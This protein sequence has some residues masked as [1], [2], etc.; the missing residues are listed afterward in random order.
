MRIITDYG[1]PALKI[2]YFGMSVKLSLALFLL[3]AALAPFLV[4]L[5]R[6]RS[7]GKPVA[8]KMRENVKE[9]DESEKSAQKRRF[10]LLSLLYWC[11]ASLRYI[12]DLMVGEELLGKLCSGLL[13]YELPVSATLV[14]LSGGVLLIRQNQD[15]YLRVLYN[16][17]EALA[18]LFLAATQYAQQIPIPKTISV[19]IG[20]WLILLLLW[21][22]LLWM[23]S[24]EFSP[25]KQELTEEERIF[26]PLDNPEEIFPRLRPSVA[27]L[28]SLI[29][30]APPEPY[31]ICVSGGWGSGKTSVVNAALAQLQ[32][33]AERPAAGG[34]HAAGAEDGSGR[35]E[36]VL[37][38]RYEVIRINALEL[39]E[40]R[41]LLDHAFSE[42]RRCLK[43]QGVYVGI[44]SEYRDFVSSAIAGMSNGPLA[45]LFTRFLIPDEGSYRE[46]RANL[47]S[48]LRE[49][50]GG[51]R[52]LIVVDDMERC[53]PEKTAQY[54]FF[55]KEIAAMSHCVAIFVTDFDFL[56]QPPTLDRELTVQER[57]TGENT[58]QNKSEAEKRRDQESRQQEKARYYEKFFNVRLD[59]PALSPKDNFRE[60]EKQ[61]RHQQLLSNAGRVLTDE[62][63]YPSEIIDT[64]EQD[65]LDLEGSLDKRFTEFL[66][67]P[68]T[69]K[70]FLF[71]RK[72]LYEKID[73]AFAEQEERAKRDG[74]PPISEEDILRRFENIRLDRILFLLAFMEACL[75]A[76][77]A[78]LQRNGSTYWDT[79]R[80]DGTFTTARKLIFALGQ[81]SLFR[82]NEVHPFRF[83]PDSGKLN[84]DPDY[85]QKQARQF[86]DFLFHSPS[87]LPTA[88]TG[89][90]S[91][92]QG[93]LDT[94]ERLHKEPLDSKKC[95][96]LE[97]NFN[98]KDVLRFVIRDIPPEFSGTENGQK[99]IYP[100]KQY[101]EALIQILNDT[102]GS[103]QAVKNLLWFF[104]THENKLSSEL[105][106]LNAMEVMWN[107]FQESGFSDVDIAYLQKFSEFSLHY[108]HKSLDVLRKILLNYEDNPHDSSDSPLT[109]A[110][111]TFFIRFSQCSNADASL[112]LYFRLIRE[113][114]NIRKK[115]YAFFQAPVWQTLS[116]AAS[117]FTFL[118]ELTNWL[119]GDLKD[120]GALDKP[121]GKAEFQKLQEAEADLQALRKILTA[122]GVLSEDRSP[123]ISPF[124]V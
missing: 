87:K 48:L 29:E 27:E 96:E 74:Q 7:G 57:G 116:D 60:L 101:F 20:N 65:G 37:R 59:L 11:A 79:F 78:L 16:G 43:R 51:G 82:D 32:R 106:R 58:A 35:A 124:A 85:L 44:G 13:L 99:A 114:A 76:E 69:M 30:N 86:V 9:Q 110:N 42:I 3:A 45:S 47:E 117:G 91:K 70:R 102:Y 107:K 118:H 111:M 23:D 46:R 112:L 12:R 52:F 120:R 56:P 73:C 119:E 97:K 34:S 2:D 122:L 6:D 61:I 92:E 41:E 104:P 113:Q 72:R 77:Y 36:S 67:R 93:Y 38:R 115:E 53:P 103:S 95:A 109:D 62:Y 15:R 8:V 5:E 18:I 66:S 55:T 21:A 83:D 64:I 33:T 94:L 71:L 123:A 63:P 26:G 100:K 24:R 17:M 54:I 1:Y 75:P 22:A 81:G 89:Y 80:E 39:D 121:E 25:P 84:A 108:V 105:S 68:R 4:W 14:A 10:I 31:S 28:V 19:S 50:T 98:W 90:T 40:P 49:S 88:L